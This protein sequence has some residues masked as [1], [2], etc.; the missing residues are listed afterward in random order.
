MPADDSRVFRIP[1]ADTTLPDDVPSRAC[2]STGC[3]GTMYLREPLEDPPEPVHLEFPRYA[4]WVCATDP[5]HVELLTE[6]QWF[7]ATLAQRHKRHRY[8]MQKMVH[9]RARA[10]G[11]RQP[12]RLTTWF[13]AA[14]RWF[15]R[16]HSGSR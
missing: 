10:G 14:R 7:K 16:P 3:T 1:E 8:D 15:T 6:S 12:S 9:S 13:N 5:S 11:E 2:T 4:T